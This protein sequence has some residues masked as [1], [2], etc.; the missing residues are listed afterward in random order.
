MISSG[1]F[2]SV[3]GGVRIDVHFLFGGSNVV[4]VQGRKLVI[5]EY[6]DI[7]KLFK[8]LGKYRIPFVTLTQELKNNRT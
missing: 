1:S 4:R 6:A 3:A 8:E 5:R 7:T 2:R